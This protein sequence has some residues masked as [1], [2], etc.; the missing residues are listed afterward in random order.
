MP[1]LLELAWRDLRAG[2]RQLWVLAA[3]LVLGVSLVAA[4]GGLYRQVADG[5]RDDA[6]LLFGGDVEVAATAPLPT[7]ALDWMAARGTVSRVLELRTML[8]TADGR[9][10]LVELM[11]TDAAYPLYGAVELAPAMPLTDALALRDGLHGVALDA[12]LAL[13]LGLQPGDRVAVGDAELRVG[14]VVQRQPDRSLRA[15]WG[16][17]PVLLSDAALQATGLVQ[18]LSRVDH[19]HRVRMAPGSAPSAAAWRDAFIAAHPGIDAEVRSFD[20]RSDRMTEVL[21]QIGSGLLLIGFAALFIGGLGVF[22]SVQTWLQGRLVS[23]ATLR[24]V[25][26]RNGRLAAFVLLQIGLLA[27]LASL[28]GVLLGIGVAAGVAQLAAERAPV[29]LLV[30]G[31]WQPALLALLFGV[32]TALT[33]SLPALGRALSVSPAVLF[34]GADAAALMTPARARW[35]TAGAGLLLLVLLV[36]SL[37]DP[38]FGLAFV[39]TMGLLLLLLDGLTR[40]LRRAAARWQHHGPLPLQLALAGLQHPQSPLRTALL[41]MGSALTLMVAC[42]LVVFTL[43][44]TLQDTVPEQA[45]ALVMY[46]VQTGQIDLLRQTLQTGPDTTVRTAPLVLGRLVAVNGQALREG[47]DADRARESLDEHKLSDRSGN[48]DDVVIDRGAWWPDDHRGEALVAME[49]REA[50]GLG[51]QVGDRLRFEIM[52]SPVDVTLSAIYSQRRLQSRL[53]LEAI[54]SDGVLDPFITRHVGAAWMP[55]GQALQAQD[56][57]AAVAP[58]IATARTEA[59]LQ[60]SRRLLERAGSGLAVVA[61]VCLAASLLVLASVVAASRSR[62]VF[63]ATVMHA[64]GARHS[65]LRRVLWWEYLVL[66]AITAGLAW[67]A[68][69]LW[70]T[71]LLK[72]Q[73]DMTPAGLYWTG[74]ATVVGVCAFS[75]LLGGR[76][77]TAQWRLSP[78][79]LLRSGG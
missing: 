78:A 20:E 3:C 55:P 79:L 52:G 33:F 46:D 4:G 1:F 68:G 67:L 37:P 31:L 10:Q 5:L 56:R 49:D 44:R 34:R 77:L 27:L 64:L 30:Q 50:D 48:F 51:L 23:L 59:L 58:N 66:A 38:R 29:R 21:G 16:A 74:A 60:E 70:A 14:A 73:L 26:L 22:N 8:R 47:G 24:A 71:V 76:Y 63:E 40:L 57:L 69:S 53:W 6:R 18:P 19:L 61:G 65:L 12:A 45:P 72:W 13:R 28:V 54:F 43:L 15:D 9:A 32:L 11:S 75:L 41:S 42:T 39:L 7:A 36:L 25:G 2:G 17:A 35:L 62:Q